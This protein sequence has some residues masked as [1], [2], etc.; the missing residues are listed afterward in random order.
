M[1]NSFFY[2]YFYNG[3]GV[4][5]SVFNNDNL[6]DIHFLS[7]LRKNKLFM[8]EGNLKFKNVSIKANAQGRDGFYTRV[9]F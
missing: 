6:P 5:V 1:M 7:N 4:A 9:T 8:N 2:E 3:G